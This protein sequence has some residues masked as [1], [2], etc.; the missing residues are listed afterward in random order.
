MKEKNV[1]WPINTIE[2]WPPGAMMRFST[3]SSFDGR[4]TTLKKFF[5]CGLVVANDGIE[6]II[7]LWPDNCRER[8]KTYYVA[9]LNAVCISRVK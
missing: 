4:M 1:D 3:S 5:A 8:L 6:K 2:A 7:V 9:N